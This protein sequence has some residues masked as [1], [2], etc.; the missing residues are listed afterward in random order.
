MRNKKEARY[1][2]R[3][4]SDEL[5]VA[6]EV[7]GRDMPKILRGALRAEVAKRLLVIKPQGR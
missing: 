4:D 1:E 6:K 2:F 7:L 3:L 5:A